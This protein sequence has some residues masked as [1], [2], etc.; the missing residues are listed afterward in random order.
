ME[1]ACWKSLMGMRNFVFSRAWGVKGTK[2]C[3]EYVL[4]KFELLN[5]SD[6]RSF[7]I[8]SVGKK[9]LVKGV[10]KIVEFMYSLG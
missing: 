2:F 9:S 1:H 8:V 4:I 5:S 6:E 3:R 10:W 7:L